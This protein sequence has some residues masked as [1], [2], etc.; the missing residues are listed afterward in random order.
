M[1]GA[2]SEPLQK[3]QYLQAAWNCPGLAAR[4]AC[5]LELFGQK[6]GGGWRFFTADRGTLAALALRGGAAFGC[7]IF[8]TQ[9]MTNL[10]Q[11]EVYPKIFFSY[12]WPSVVG[13]AL[14]VLLSC[15]M[16]ACDWKVIQEKK[17]QK[18]ANKQPKQEK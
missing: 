7:Q 5:Q 8:M 11:R 4:L 15:Y 14:A 10:A 1:I 12:S 2:V 16:A 3:R 6:P 18:A 13:F 9:Y 17:Q